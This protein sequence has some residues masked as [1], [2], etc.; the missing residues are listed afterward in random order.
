M[1]GAFIGPIIK[2]EKLGVFLNTALDLIRAQRLPMTQ[3]VWRLR[4]EFFAIGFPV[5][6]VLVELTLTDSHEASAKLLTQCAI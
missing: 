4:Y 3:G 5:L 6:S 1:S 2:D